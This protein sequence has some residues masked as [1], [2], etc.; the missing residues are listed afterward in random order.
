MAPE[1]ARDSKDVGPPA[2]VYALGAILYFLLTGRPPFVGES[3]TDLL[4]K[5]VSDRP[6]PLRKLRPDVPTE[7][8]SLCLRC[9]AKAPADRFTDAEALAVALAPITD[10]Y[11]APSASFSPSPARVGPRPSTPSTPGLPSAIAKAAPTEAATAPKPNR[12]PLLIGVAV[13]AVLLVGVIAFA[14]TRG[15]KGDKKDEVAK[16]EPPPATTAPPQVTPA[17]AQ[18]PTPNPAPTPGTNEDKLALPAVNHADFG[19]KVELVAT[20][21]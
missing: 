3:L 12:K 18:T 21:A 5:V 15:D 20:A 2:D 8:E 16:Q 7:L 1:Q 9:L 13:T 6:V 4:L 17:P 11:L 10:Q 19:L 14:A